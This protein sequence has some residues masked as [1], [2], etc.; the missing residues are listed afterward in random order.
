MPVAGIFL[1]FYHFIF[2]LF[3]VLCHVKSFSRTLAQSNQANEYEKNCV[4]PTFCLCRAFVQ[5]YRPNHYPQLSEILRERMGSY[6][7]A[8]PEQGYCTQGS[9]S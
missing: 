9:N 4:N 3:S 2:L 8:G 5:P 1:P 6:S 7:S